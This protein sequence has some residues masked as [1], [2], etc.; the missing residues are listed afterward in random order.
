LSPYSIIEYFEMVFATLLS[1]ERRKH[2]LH[3]YSPEYA[4]K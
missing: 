1:I 4:L 3:R 2:F